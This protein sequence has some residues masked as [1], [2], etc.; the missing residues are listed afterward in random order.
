LN[1][2][3][4]LRDNECLLALITHGYKKRKQRACWKSTVIPGNVIYYA[5]VLYSLWR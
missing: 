4:E 1:L 5:D 3:L 2:D